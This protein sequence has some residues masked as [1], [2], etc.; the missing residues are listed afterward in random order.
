MIDQVTKYNLCGLKAEY[1]GSTQSSFERKRKVLNREFQLVFA[2]PETIIENPTNR[3]RNMLL[4]SENKQKLICVAVDEAHCVKVWGTEFRPTLAEIG[5]S[6]S[7][8]SNS[9]N[10]VALTATATT[11]T[12]HIVVQKFPMVNPVLVAIFPH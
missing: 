6:C 8:I 2:P 9:V 7:I 4:S 11:E 1:I 5:K 12:F 10:D 3:K